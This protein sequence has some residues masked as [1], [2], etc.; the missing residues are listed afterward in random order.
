MCL[1]PILVGELIAS[2]SDGP[3]RCIGDVTEDDSGHG[4]ACASDRL[5]L[6]G[7]SRLCH[8]RAALVKNQT[9]LAPKN[10]PFRLGTPA[11]YRVGVRV[12]R[13]IEDIS[14]CT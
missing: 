14:H 6:E 5:A 4:G 2:A 7:R 13:R 9:V 3:F 12:P 1:R 10:D 11:R 8:R